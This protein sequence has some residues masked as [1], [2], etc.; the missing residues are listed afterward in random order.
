MKLTLL[1]WCQWIWIALQ[2]ITNINLESRELKNEYV[3]YINGYLLLK[4]Q[5][6]MD[7]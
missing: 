6:N 7:T 2:L 1:N 3:V 5:I 4:D